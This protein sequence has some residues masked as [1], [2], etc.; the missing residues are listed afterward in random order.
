MHP[1]VIEMPIDRQ[2]MLFRIVQEALQNTI[3]HGEASR[4][5]IVAE[6]K[7]NMLQ[8][9]IADDGKGFDANDET[10]QGVG[11]IN[12]KH[13]TKLMNGTVQWNS[14][15]NGTSVIIQLPLYAS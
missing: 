14:T 9:S 6:Q 7:E 4:I 3:K 5:S 12:I 11:I 2:M 8:V 10:I 1:P 15:K 13:R